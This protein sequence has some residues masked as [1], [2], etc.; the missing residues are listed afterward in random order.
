MHTKFK[1]RL[2]ESNRI[3]EAG[4]AFSGLPQETQELEEGYDVSSEI[5]ENKE[6]KV[7]E[8]SVE[9]SCLHYINE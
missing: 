2:F 3:K 9:N 6:M 5:R 1:R 4:F 8:E 7:L